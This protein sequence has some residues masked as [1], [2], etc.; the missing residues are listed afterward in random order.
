MKL[1][2]GLLTARVLLWDTVSSVARA[3][4]LNL[5]KV[6]TSGVKAATVLSKVVNSMANFEHEHGKF[7]EMI[8][9]CSTVLALLGHTNRQN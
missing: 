7:G 1:M 9:N 4:D 3:N 6:E 8:E 5:Q 2:L